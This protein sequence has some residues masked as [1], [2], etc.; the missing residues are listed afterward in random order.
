MIT[1]VA[2]LVALLFHP[3]ALS[4]AAF[5]TFL[6]F[7]LLTCGVSIDTYFINQMKYHTVNIQD[8]MV[9]FGNALWMFWAA[10]GSTLLAIPCLLGGA[11]GGHETTAY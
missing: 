3:A 1:G 7:A 9:H 4:V 2:F 8:N 10:V 6:G 5:L 11:T